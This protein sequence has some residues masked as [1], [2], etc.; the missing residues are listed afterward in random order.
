MAYNRAN[1]NPQPQQQQTN[2][3]AQ[4]VTPPVDTVDNPQRSQRQPLGIND[5]FGKFNSP[6]PLSATGESLTAVMAKFADILRNS[7]QDTVKL[8]PI[9]MKVFGTSLSYIVLSQA[10]VAENGEKH[11]ATF[12]LILEGS[13]PRLGKRSMRKG[14]Q[15]VEIDGTP[16][17]TY[18]DGLWNI[19]QQQMKAIV[20]TADVVIFDAGAAVLPGDLSTENGEM[21]T[22]IVA[23]ALSAVHNLLRYQNFQDPVLNMRTFAQEN[24]KVTV[25][26]DYSPKPVYDPVGNPIRSDISLTTIYSQAG[27]SIA[28]ED[29]Y[30]RNAQEVVAVDGYVVPLYNAPKRISSRRGR[31]YEDDIQIYY[32]QFVITNIQAM[33]NCNTLEIM[34]LGMYSAMVLARDYSWGAAFNN[35]DFNTTNMHDLSGVKYDLPPDADVVTDTRAADFDLHELISAVFHPDELIISMDIPEVGFDNYLWNRLADSATDKTA[36]QAVLEAANN[37]TDGNFHAIYVGDNRTPV[38]REDVRIPLGYWV[39]ADTGLKRDIREVDYLFMLNYIGGTDF[40]VV[41]S[42][43][44]TFDPTK[45]HRDVRL[46]RLLEI[47]Q[48]PLQHKAKITGYANR[49]TID[50]AFL[51]AIGEGLTEAGMPITTSNLVSVYGTTRRSSSNIARYAVSA[52]DAAEYFRP[53]RGRGRDGDDRSMRGARRSD[54]YSR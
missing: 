28:D 23:Y 32:P 40:D 13:G 15:T 45:N 12:T 27:R 6:I 3:T 47:I 5:L 41:Q 50:G 2:A 33:V 8:T 25:R 36:Q 43:D 51:S 22:L 53:N 35:K 31:D 1:N 52:R 37:L 26:A 48:E 20:Y 29:E 9:D 49:Y 16:G 21:C 38:I 42:F 39:D 7:G 34:L 19:I 24:A 18:N 30:I 46:E 44:N 17:D 10:T 4:P 11:V 14:D 54:S